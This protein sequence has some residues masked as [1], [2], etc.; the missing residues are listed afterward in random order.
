MFDTLICVDFEKV[1][2]TLN[3]QKQRESSCCANYMSF[4]TI[5]RELASS[6]TDRMQSLEGHR[7]ACAAKRQAKSRSVRSNI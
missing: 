6:Q 7:L 2:D 4:A 5:V 1:R 3:L